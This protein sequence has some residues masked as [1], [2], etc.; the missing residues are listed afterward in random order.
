MLLPKSPDQVSETQSALETEQINNR[1]K[2]N[3][4][5][6]RQVNEHAKKVNQHI[7]GEEFSAE[8]K[9]N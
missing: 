2:I 6:K 3:T 5:I 4:L 1:E 7:Y 9:K 8:K